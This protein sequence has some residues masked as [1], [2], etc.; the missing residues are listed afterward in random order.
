MVMPNLYG[1]IVGNICAGLVGGAGVVPGMNIGHRHAVFE[2][3]SVRLLDSTMVDC[4]L[5]CV[6]G[7]SVCGGRHS[8]VVSIG[9]SVDI[10]AFSPQNGRPSVQKSSKW[11]FQHSILGQGMYS[12]MKASVYPGL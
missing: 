3:V 2:Q 6:W 12:P 4:P 7:Y 5:Q 8:S 9:S 11:R 1:N 10:Q